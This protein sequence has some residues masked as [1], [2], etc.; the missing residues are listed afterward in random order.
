MRTFYF[1]SV[2]FGFFAGIFVAGSAEISQAGFAALA[3]A[4]AAVAVFLFLYSKIK[5]KELA[6]PILIFCLFLFAFSIGGIRMNQK[7][8]SFEND[9]LLGLVGKPVS[10][11][12]IAGDDVGI[13]DSSAAVKL[14]SQSILL[15][16]P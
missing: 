8:S 2:I 6:H 13:T 15:K 3:V 4:S 1:Y 5:S 14:P 12:G 7:L 10:L 9:P 16:Y 11:V